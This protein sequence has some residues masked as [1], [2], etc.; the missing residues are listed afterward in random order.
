M[1]L[2]DIEEAVL[3]LVAAGCKPPEAW[4]DRRAEAAGLRI[5]LAALE[6]L[7]QAQLRRAVLTHIRRSKTPWWPTPGL[8]LSMARGAQAALP[9]GNENDRRGAAEALADKACIE[10]VPKALCLIDKHAPG[11]RADEVQV[12]VYDE[13]AVNAALIEGMRSTGQLAKRSEEWE[14]RSAYRAAFRR[15]F[16]SELN[17]WEHQGHEVQRPALVASAPAVRA[18]TMRDGSVR[19]VSITTTE[20]AQIEQR[21]DHKTG[22]VKLLVSRL[23]QLYRTSND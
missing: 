16:V 12:Q 20:H 14:N 6:E 17:R 2:D 9:D 11:Y 23:E 3:S 19:Q 18:I 10:G 7:D 13:P 21:G 8:L 5:W 15:A 1:T 22:D 4:Q